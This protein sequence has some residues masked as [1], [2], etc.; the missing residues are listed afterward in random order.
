[1]PISTARGLRRTLERFTSDHQLGQ[2]L[3]RCINSKIDHPINLMEVCG[4]HTMTISATG[5]RRSVDPRLSL[6]SGPGCPVCVTAQQDLDLALELAQQPGV[7]LATFGDMMR[8]PGTNSSLELERSR[9]RDIRV[10]YSPLEAVRTAQENPSR[11]VVFLGVGFE[12]TAPVVAA[13]LI[14]ARRQGLTNF[15]LFCRFKTMPQ[16]LRALVQSPGLKVD[17]FILPGHVSTI[18]G[19]RP[20]EFLAQEFGKP[21][22]ITGFELLDLVQGIEMLLE[23]MQTRPEVRI[24]YTRSVH[25]DGN[26]EAQQLLAQVFVPNDAVW[27]GLGKIPASGL[28]LAPGYACFDAELH[29]GLKPKPTKGIPRGCRCGDVLLGAI[30]PIECGLFAKTCTP[31]QPLGPCMVSSEGAC[32]AYYKYE[33]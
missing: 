24:Q 32:A 11:E 20:Y 19:S 3:L 17:G 4:T 5:L 12:T 30:L 25:P 28:G 21:C 23:Q 26:P 7:I 33:R 10:V 27:R 8:V 22:C 16:A 6:T 9:G 13:S 2:A 18:I 14:L 31:E 15:L 29:F 1:M